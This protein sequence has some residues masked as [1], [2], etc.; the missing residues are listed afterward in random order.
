MKTIEFPQARHDDLIV[1]LADGSEFLLVAIDDFD[2]EIA[3]TRA[4]PRLMALNC[5][6]LANPA[7]LPVIEAVCI[8]KRLKV[9]MIC[10]TEELMG[11][12]P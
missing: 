11:A 10:T 9:P 2:R 4:N 8:A 6:H 3:R 5:R 1:R 7:M 12:K